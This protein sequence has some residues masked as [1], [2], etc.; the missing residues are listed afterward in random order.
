[1]TKI[2]YA[3][4]WPD[5][6]SYSFLTATFFKIPEREK[7]RGCFCCLNK[8]YNWWRAA[9]LGPQRASFEGSDRFWAA[10]FL[11]YYFP[12]ISRA[13]GWAQ[14]LRGDSREQGD[15]GEKGSVGR[16]E[17]GE[18]G[19]R[20]QVWRGVFKLLFVLKPLTLCRTGSVPP[21]CVVWNVEW[22][23]IDDT[24]EKVFLETPLNSSAG[25][26][27]SSEELSCLWIKMYGSKLTKHQVGYLW[28]DHVA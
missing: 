20:T 14:R 12:S 22:A 19:W 6:A 7:V 2:Q 25:V 28:H 4:L 9:F 26:S 18:G 15:V 11:C 13:G 8:N 16:S 27:C 24:G 10:Q 17:T 5:S 1:M 21:G 23:W 3:D